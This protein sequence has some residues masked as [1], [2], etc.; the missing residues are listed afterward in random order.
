MAE[1]DAA[2]LR[3]MY[4]DERMTVTEIART[5]RVRKQTV[6]DA[7]AQWDIPRRRRGLRRRMPELPFT[8]GE[9][10]RLVDRKGVRAV[11]RRLSV[12]PDVV[13]AY[14]QREPLP[15]GTKRTLDD[16]SV[17]SAY[18]AGMPIAQLAAEFHTSRHTI[19]RSLRRSFLRTMA[20]A[21]EPRGD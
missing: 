14:L 7:L 21:R 5:L 15:R 2:T 12:A 11:A 9:L 13:Y 17:W 1:L 8:A 18:Q 3:R 6:C 20:E 16:T 19:K 4:V 10:R